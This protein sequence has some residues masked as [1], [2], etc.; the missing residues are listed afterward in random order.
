[1]RKIW[2]LFA[3]LIFI[4]DG[5]EGYYWA[6]RIHLLS[7]ENDYRLF[8]FLLFC[9][10][11]APVAAIRLNL[12]QEGKSSDLFRPPLFTTSVVLG[13]IIFVYS[14]PESVHP[15]RFP[16]AL[17]IISGA[18]LGC[19]LPLRYLDRGLSRTKLELPKSEPSPL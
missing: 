10:C 13:V 6:N 15:P 17:A 3:L 8:Y 19:L 16:F 5:I 14:H 1:M 9:L 12:A 11:A 4:A 2:A 7:V 18:V